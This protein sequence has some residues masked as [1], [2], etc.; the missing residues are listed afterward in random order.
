MKKLILTLSTLFLTPT[1]VFASSCDQ[2]FP[3]KKEIVVPGT[4]VLCNTFYATLYDTIKKEAIFS[5]EAFLPHADKVE[6][7][8]DFHADS[9]VKNSPTP[10]DYDKTGF[11]RGHL[12]PAADADDDTQMSDTFLM[13]NMTPQEPTVNRIS[14]RM[15]ESSVRAMPANYIVTG[16]IYT[17]STKTI[18]KHKVPVP[19][20]YYKIVYLKDGSVKSYVAANTVNAPVTET[21]LDQV[22]K[23]AG[24]KFH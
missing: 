11:D 10:A 19:T 2:F 17:S 13:T 18:G 9:R 7:T 1:T 23:S 14:W 6:R 3:N 21:T 5:T 8:N 16:E 4:T 12:T 15:L 24:I 22:E 20:N